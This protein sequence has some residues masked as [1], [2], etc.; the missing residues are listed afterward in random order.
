[1]YFSIQILLYTLFK[2]K[3]IMNENERM[4]MLYKTMRRIKMH[5]ILYIFFSKKYE[6]Y[7]CLFQKN[8]L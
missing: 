1:M 6:E 3:S 2:I 7:Y 5:K 8:S 4:M